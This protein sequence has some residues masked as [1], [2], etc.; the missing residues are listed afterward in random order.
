MSDGMYLCM[1]VC[2]LYSYTVEP[3]KDT[4][5][6]SC[7][8]LCKEVVRGDILSSVY[9]RVFSACPLL[10]GLSSSECPLSEVSLY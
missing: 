2:M 7:F 6:T 3:F 5:G 9:T 4:L 10:G 1:Y 8:V